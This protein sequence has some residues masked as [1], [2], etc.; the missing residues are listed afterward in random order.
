VD[1]RFL[2]LAAAFC[3]AL[4]A[5]LQQRGQDRLARDGNPVHDVKGIFRLVVVP[6]WLLGTAVLLAG[7]VIQGVALDVGKLVVVQPLLV[8]TLVFALPLGHWI[9]QQHVTGRQALGAL[10]VVGGLAMFIALGDPDQGVDTAATWELVAAIVVVL[11]GSAVLLVVGNRMA[12]SHKAAVFGAVAGALFG[13]SAT[14]DK[15][16]F[17]QASFGSGDMFTEWTLYALVLLGVI[18][19]GVQ[20][21]SLATGQLA[22]AMAAVSV[23][24]PFV[25][26]LVGILIYEERLSQPGWH[27]LLAGAA[28]AVA[29]AGAVIVTLGNRERAAPTADL[30]SAGI[31]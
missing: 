15:P 5:T 28:L 20:Q 8:T 25:S 31:A 29:F 12:P 2:A 14:F 17:S 1:G 13:L 4:A 6:I 26:T 27:K 19:F 24:N 21:L 18:A 23:V 7:Y 16:T 9:T 11:A 30:P 3:F 10:V 22:P